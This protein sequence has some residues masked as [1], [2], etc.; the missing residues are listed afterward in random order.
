MSA[1]VYGTLQYPQV[2]QALISRVPRMEPAVIR[3]YQRH[4]IRGQVFPG[5]VPAAADSC[6]SG[7]VLFDLQPAEMEILDEFEGDEYY[8]QAV[9]AELASGGTADT[10]V[11]LWQD[12]LRP[13]LYGEW[14]PEDFR[15][16]ELER[17]V[18]MCR[19]F[20]QDVAAHRGWKGNFPSP[21]SSEQ[22]EAAAEAAAA[23]EQQQWGG[24]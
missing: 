22:A 19:Q 4:S 11:Y 15:E 14:D 9:A 1:F 21:S 3:G 18:V 8:K 17:Y 10:I 2:L 6:V 24:V 20:A 7:L 16:R 12:S 13:L 23:L 5:T